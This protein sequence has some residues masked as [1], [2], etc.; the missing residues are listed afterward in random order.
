MEAIFV[1]ISSN[2]NKIQNLI[3]QANNTFSN[4][5]IIYDTLLNEELNLNLLK[6]EQNKI[7]ASIDR[8][9]EF[10]DNLKIIYD[11]VNLSTISS[12][13]DIDK[14]LDIHKKAII[15]VTN[16]NLEIVDLNKFKNELTNIYNKFTINSF[17]INNV[18][19]IYK[20]SITKIDNIFKRINE[21]GIDII[22]DKIYSIILNNK[23]IYETNLLD[24]ELNKIKII[25]DEELNKIKIIQDEELNKIKIIKDE[26][27]NKIKIDDIIINKTDNI[28]I[29]NDTKQ[30]ES[31]DLNII[32]I[33]IGVVILIIFIFFLFYKNNLL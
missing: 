33:I 14:L 28:I 20:Q 25:K 26:E 10:L 13:E 11:T 3:K 4:I 9:N 23:N 27:L 18:K 2:V 31:S 17:I 16:I 22:I 19:E 1:I 6:I 21:F 24:E 30:E 8:L 7:L 32:F 5:K 12:R 29:K 15:L